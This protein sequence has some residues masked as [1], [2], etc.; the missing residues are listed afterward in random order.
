MG[1]VIEMRTGTLL[2]AFALAFGVGGCGDS[3]D[4]GEA[5][6]PRGR[7]DV[8][9]VFGAQ[10]SECVSAPT[11]HRTPPQECQTV[12]PLGDHDRRVARLEDG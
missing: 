6:D 7:R 1:E 4:A 2:L 10:L 8:R 9:R 11:P 5:A 3:E 12:L